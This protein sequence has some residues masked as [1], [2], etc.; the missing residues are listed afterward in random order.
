M[1]KDF[2]SVVSERARYGRYRVVPKQACKSDCNGADDE[3]EHGPSHQSMRAPWRHNP[4]ER[5]DHL[6]PVARYLRSQVG[7][8]WDDVYSDICRVF[9]KNHVV[10]HRLNDWLSWQVDQTIRLVNG[11]F[12]NESG[13]CVSANSLYVHPQSGV[14]TLEPPRARRRYENKPRFESVVIDQE[15]RLV[16]LDNLWF[17]VELATIPG[18]DVSERPFDVV[19]KQSPFADDLKYAWGNQFYRNWLPGLY[20]ACKRQANTREIRQ[21][22]G[23]NA[24]LT[25]D[26]KPKVKSERESFKRPRYRHC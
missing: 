18:A 5:R 25:S 3:F 14:L 20:A 7:R 2:T 8:P 16:K 22:C 23:A 15:H 24:D 13:H 6:A 26:D 19:L 4:K 12:V 10:D 1:R 9:R 21:Y 17:V 11:E